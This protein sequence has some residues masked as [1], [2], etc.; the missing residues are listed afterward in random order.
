MS[1][2][3]VNET[4]FEKQ[5]EGHMFPVSLC[6]SCLLEGVAVHGAD[7]ADVSLDP[8]SRQVLSCCVKLLNGNLISTSALPCFTLEC[9]PDGKRALL[10]RRSEWRLQLFSAACQ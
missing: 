8:I 7:P 9:S 2:L 10:F 6:S 4:S 1:L 5:A 3:N